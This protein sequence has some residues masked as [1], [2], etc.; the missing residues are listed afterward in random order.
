MK[1]V[2]KHN[3]S[4]LCNITIKNASEKRTLNIPKSSILVIQIIYS[5]ILFSIFFSNFLPVFL[6]LTC[7]LEDFLAENFVTPQT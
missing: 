6:T 5:T 2:R 3:G 1:T 4:F 7:M